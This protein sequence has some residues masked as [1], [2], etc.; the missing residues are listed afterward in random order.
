MIDLKQFW[1]NLQDKI[2]HNHMHCSQYVL[3]MKLTYNH[4]KS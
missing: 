2:M 4:T 3:G 1:S